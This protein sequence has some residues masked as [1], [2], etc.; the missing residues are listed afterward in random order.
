LQAVKVNVPGVGVGA[1]DTGSASPLSPLTAIKSAVSMVW[2]TLSATRKATPVVHPKIVAVKRSP[3]FVITLG[4]TNAVCGKGE[5][6][7]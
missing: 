2:P 3:L 1:V 5:A 7:L 4:E 6:T